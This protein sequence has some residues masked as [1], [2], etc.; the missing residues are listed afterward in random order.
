[1]GTGQT[2]PSG[3]LENT[4]LTLYLLHCLV[5][6]STKIKMKEIKNKRIRKRLTNIYV[7]GFKS[8]FAVYLVVKSSP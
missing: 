5:S 4:W 7:I 3:I 6:E 8:A 1:M 2:D